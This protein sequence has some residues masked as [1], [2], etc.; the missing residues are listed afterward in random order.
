VTAAWQRGLYA[1]TDSELIAPRDLASQVDAA[2]T[3]GAVLVQYRDKTDGDRQRVKRARAVLTVCRA[4]RVPLIIN[5]DIALAAAVGADGVHLGR[6]DAQLAAARQRLGPRAIIGVSC[7]NDLPRAVTAAE[8][9]ADYVAF[10]RFFPS[11]TKPNAMQA[12][13]ETLH[14]ARRCLNIPIAAIGGITAANGNALITAGADLLAV[15]HGVFGRADVAAAARSIA[16]LFGDATV[17]RNSKAFG[18]QQSGAMP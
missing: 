1:V 9:G 12:D 3:G 17:K 15:I 5:D 11:R 16:E 8:T 10:G 2:V 13:V 4:R 7:Y 6:D 14:R 18:A